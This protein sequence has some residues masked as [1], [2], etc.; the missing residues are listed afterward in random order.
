MFYYRR[1][2]RKDWESK[3]NGSRTFLFN[4]SPSNI[5]AKEG[6]AKHPYEHFRETPTPVTGTL[7]ARSRSRLRDMLSALA[8]T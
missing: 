1:G 7:S 4:R 5:F 2:D 6:P 3:V 8:R